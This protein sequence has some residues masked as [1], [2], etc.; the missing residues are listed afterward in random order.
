MGFLPTRHPSSMRAFEHS[1]GPGCIANH[2]ESGRCIRLARIARDS[3][4]AR[5]AIRP[6]RVEELAEI[7]PPL[8][9][10]L[11]RCPHCSRSSM[12]H[13]VDVIGCKRG[14]EALDNIPSGILCLLALDESPQIRRS[15]GPDSRFNGTSIRPSKAICCIELD[16]QSI[17]N[18]AEHLSRPEGTALYYVALC[19]FSRLVNYLVLAHAEDVNPKCGRHGTPLHAAP[20][21]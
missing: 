19:G 11:Q 6:L 4:A 17:D 10:S 8:P 12:P 2:T 14:Q 20:V 16:N 15:G 21:S 7:Y 3:L 18:L 5:A 9:H 13:G 1:Q